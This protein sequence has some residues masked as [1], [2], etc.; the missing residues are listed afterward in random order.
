MECASR[1]RYASLAGYSEPKLGADLMVRKVFVYRC[2]G[3]CKL[4]P[5]A[6]LSLL[7]IISL[8][9]WKERVKYENQLAHA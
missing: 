1:S 7:R 9:R 8:L 4:G 5:A 2:T 6:H 3:F